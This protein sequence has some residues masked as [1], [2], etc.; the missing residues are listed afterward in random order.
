MNSCHAK[1]VK[2]RSQSPSSLLSWRNV[3]C[4]NFYCLHAI[5]QLFVRQWENFVHM[6]SIFGVGL[7]NSFASKRAS[8]RTA[9]NAIVCRLHGTIHCQ[10]Q[11]C[12]FSIRCFIYVLDDFL[13]L[14]HMNF[15]SCQQL[16]SAAAFFHK[17]FLM[18]IV[19]INSLF[20]LIWFQILFL[21][22][23]H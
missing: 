20:V 3:K 10:C 15:C 23:L 19:S 14:N 1:N 12:D 16:A 13:P 8:A 7:H 6:D 5:E 22:L 2:S 11:F 4:T 17:N 9:S 21:R 18:N